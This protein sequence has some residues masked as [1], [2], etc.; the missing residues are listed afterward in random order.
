MSHCQNLCGGVGV[1][2]GPEGARGG[3]KSQNRY[4]EEARAL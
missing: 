1:G 3:R 2:L 4:E